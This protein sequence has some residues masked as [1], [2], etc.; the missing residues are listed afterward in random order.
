MPIGLQREWE[1][2]VPLSRVMDEHDRAARLADDASPPAN[3]NE[4][5]RVAFGGHGIRGAQGIDHDE[6]RPEL[7]GDL[8]D[9]G[10][11]DG[12]A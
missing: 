6:A 5:V 4:R 9:G 8:L 2:R 7:L 10:A 3:Q 11:G 12:T 1:F